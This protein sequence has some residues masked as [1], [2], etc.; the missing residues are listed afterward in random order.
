MEHFDLSKEQAQHIL[1]GELRRNESDQA[2]FMVQ[3]IDSLEVT[4]ESHLHDSATSSNDH[5]CMD[6]HAFVGP[7][8]HHSSF[9][10]D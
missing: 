6:A 5:D 7:E 3:G 10:N 8:A 1:K 9:D 2:C 4:S